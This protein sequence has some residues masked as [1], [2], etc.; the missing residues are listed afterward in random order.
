MGTR[1][2]Q[3][4]ISKTGDLKIQQY[5]QWDGYP[6]GQG[7]DIL[8]YLRSANL[9]K[10]QEN[11]EKTPLITKKQGEKINKDEKWQNYY[12]YLSRDCGS[13]IHQMIEDGAVKFVQHTDEEECKQW[14]EGFYT[15]DFK[16]NVFITEYDGQTEEFDLDNLPSV[17]EYLAK[18]KD[19]DE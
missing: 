19:P 15:I 9:K 18:F 14:C 12:P 7:V 1:H 11:L 2:R 5:G 3:A 4:V 17:K 8:K 10:Y 13:K 16:R 6:K